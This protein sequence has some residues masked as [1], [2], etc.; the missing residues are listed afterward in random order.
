MFKIIDLKIVGNSNKSSD[1]DLQ[2]YLGNYQLEDYKIAK[3]L[4]AK[5]NDDYNF[6]EPK[7]N[8]YR[9]EHNLEII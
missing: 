7:I 6:W 1:L 4:N 3:R 9:K 8:S 2:V 5:D